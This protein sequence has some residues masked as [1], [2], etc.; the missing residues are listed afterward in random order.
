VCDGEGC[1]SKPNNKKTEKTNPDKPWNIML[2]IKRGHHVGWAATNAPDQ[3]S[4]DFLNEADACGI[5]Q[6]AIGCLFALF[7]RFAIIGPQNTGPN[8]FINFT[9]TYDETEGIVISD[10]ILSNYSGDY[11]DITGMKYESGDQI[12][13]SLG[14]IRLSNGFGSDF[15]VDNS[16]TFDGDNPLTITLE[17]KQ[18][19]YMGSA[20]YPGPSQSF[21]NIVITLPSLPVL[22]SYW[23]R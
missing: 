11:L 10:F 17:Y 8:F 7:E 23:Q 14:S 5:P 21:P 12:V 13:S 19:I 3:S 1:K 18:T 16:I 2:H 20:A 6:A 22:K 4:D 15:H 9:A